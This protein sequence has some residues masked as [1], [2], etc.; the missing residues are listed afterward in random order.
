VVLI[1]VRRYS[2]HF[3]ILAEEV[4]ARGIPLVI[5]TDTQ[6]YWARQL[7]DKVLMLSLGA[8]RVWHSF[9]DFTSLFS[10]LLGAVARDMGNVYGRIGEI[11]QLRQKFIGHAGPS[12]GGRAGPRTGS[13]RKTPAA[14]KPRRR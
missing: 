14:R 10:L 4:A 5:I 6:C 1:D 7:T 13:P 12:L 8:D 9:T 2:R 3:R 11:N